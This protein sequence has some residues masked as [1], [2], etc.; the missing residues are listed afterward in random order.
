MRVSYPIFLQINIFDEHIKIG[1]SDTNIEN[2][3][4]PIEILFSVVNHL[5][6]ME[7]QI[8]TNYVNINECI[9]LLKQV[10]YQLLKKADI[11][12]LTDKQRASCF[13][14]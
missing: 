13:S 7:M 4:L 5:N 3:Y 2:L 6:P 9:V 11:K 10:S 14:K 12:N 8:N 1:F